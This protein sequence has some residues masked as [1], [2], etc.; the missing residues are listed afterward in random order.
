MKLLRKINLLR[1][2]GIKVFMADLL[3]SNIRIPKLTARWKDKVF[4]SWLREHY[5]HI[6]NKY[7]LMNTTTE[8]DN[9]SSYVWSMWWQGDNNLPEVIQLCFGN[10]KRHCGDHKFIV[11]SKD[12]YRDYITLPDYILKKVNDGSITLTHLSDIIRMYLLSHY[13]GLWID[14]TILVTDDIPEKVFSENFF[15]LKRTCNT[16]LYNVSMNRWAGNLMA[17]KKGNI[18]CSFCLDVFLEFWKSHSMLIDYVFIDYVIAWAYL[19]ISEC[20]DMINS[21]QEGNFAFDDLQ[22]LLNSV[23]QQEKYNALMK[24]T[25][26][27]KLTYKHTF[28]K[29]I[30]GK[31]TFYGYIIKNL[32]P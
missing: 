11:I 24:N 2:F 21:V 22:P 31:E 6:L 17:A 25:H 28:K 23:W 32:W 9:S 16:S 14:A 10:I 30:H 12:N 3:A 5:Q 26:F 7:L 13:G 20:T 18:L 29:D 19:D 4:T 1:E 8:H 27:F 15:T